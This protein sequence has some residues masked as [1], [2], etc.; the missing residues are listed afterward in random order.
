MRCKIL[1]N[2]KGIAL[3]DWVMMRRFLDY[4]FWEGLKGKNVS[5]VVF[6]NEERK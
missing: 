1:G 3:A 2:G 5:V 4:G 6:E